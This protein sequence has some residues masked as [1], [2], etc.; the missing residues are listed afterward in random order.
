MNAVKQS[1]AY[2][3]EM[4]AGSGDVSLFARSW[5]PESRVRGVVVIVH[6]FLAHSAM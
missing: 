3:E 1:L 2:R 6:G 4:F 5:R